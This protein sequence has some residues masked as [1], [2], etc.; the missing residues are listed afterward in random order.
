MTADQLLHKMRAVLADEREGILR[1]DA[2]LIARANDAKELVLRA[3]RETPAAQRAPLFAAL[4]ELKPDLRC[5]QILLAHAQAY[6][7]DVREEARARDE[8][9]TS[10]VVPLVRRKAS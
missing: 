9:R 2:V 10:S 8:R 3:L 5:N 6:L 4:E 7:E 1:F